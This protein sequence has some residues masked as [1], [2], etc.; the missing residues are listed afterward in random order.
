MLKVNTHIIPF[1]PRNQDYYLCVRAC[2]CLC[3][4]VLAFGLYDALAGQPNECKQLI[5]VDKTHVKILCGQCMQVL[6]FEA[7]QY[8]KLQPFIVTL[9]FGNRTQCI[10][11]IFFDFFF[12]VVDATNKKEFSVCMFYSHLRLLLLVVFFSLSRKLYIELV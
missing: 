12:V 6:V 11:W 10:Q 3:V 2:V 7:G 9:P 1:Y 5:I 4:C 8:S